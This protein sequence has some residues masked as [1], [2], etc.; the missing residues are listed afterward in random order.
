MTIVATNLHPVRNV[1]RQYLERTTG[2]IHV[3][4]V[5]TIFSS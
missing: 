5:T 4:E 3:I 1:I 2:D